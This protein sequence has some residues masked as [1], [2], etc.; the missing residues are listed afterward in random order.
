M[1]ARVGK[2][3]PVR[4]FTLTCAYGAIL[5]A[6]TLLN[7]VGADRW[8]FGT[9]NLYLPQA[10]WAA[11]GVLLVAL[12]LAIARHRARAPLLCIAWVLGPIMGFC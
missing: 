3:A 11:P 6:L 2:K 5:G 1:T 8:W 7:L 10:A 9:V 12:S 4:F